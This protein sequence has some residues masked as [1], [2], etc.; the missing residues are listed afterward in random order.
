MFCAE[1][2]FVGWTAIVL[3]Q[4]H[5]IIRVLLRVHFHGSSIRSPRV[6]YTVVT[7]RAIIVA[8]PLPPFWVDKPLVKYSPII[9]TVSSSS[10]PEQEPIPPLGG[11]HPLAPPAKQP[12]PPHCLH[13]QATRVVVLW[14][15]SGSRQDDD[16]TSCPSPSRSRGGIIM[17]Q[18]IEYS[19][20]EGST[21]K[22][23]G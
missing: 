1:G 14:R 9:L 6:N 23:F 18:Y 15:K 19:A 22:L 3:I 7:L 10:D 4:L 20:P 17:S 16:I 12:A 13:P 11:G 5:S 2:H 8:C 21:V